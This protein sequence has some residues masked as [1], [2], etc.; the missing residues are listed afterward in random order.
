MCDGDQGE[1]VAGTGTATA[2]ASERALSCPFVSV[3]ILTICIFVF[4]SSDFSHT[5]IHTQDF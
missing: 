1:T 4:R 3:F 2:T 5:Y